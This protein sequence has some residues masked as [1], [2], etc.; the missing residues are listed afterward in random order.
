MD[1]N[2]MNLTL[3]V[4]SHLLLSFQWQSLC[5]RY[6]FHLVF[7]GAQFE[8]WP[9]TMHFHGFPQSHQENNMTDL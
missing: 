7:G 3:Y 5:M 1:I 2:N 9:K 8:P 6:W 4:H